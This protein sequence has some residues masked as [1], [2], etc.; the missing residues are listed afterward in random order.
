M[1]DR[2]MHISRLRLRRD[3][4]AAM[5]VLGG[6]LDAGRA[7]RLLWTLFA[8]GGDGRRDFLFRAGQGP[9]SADGDF[10]I[11]SSRPPED[12]RGLW[13]IEAKPYDPYLAAGQRLSFKLRANPTVMRDG[14]R[15]DVVTD[16][17]RRLGDTRV[18]TNAE[19]WE[20]AGRDW[21]AARA[22]RLGIAL[23][24]LRADAYRVERLARPGGARPATIASLDLS[25]A[26]IVDDPVMLRAAL[27]AG[28]GHGKA[29]GCGLL[30]V[31]PI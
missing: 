14:K 31:K 29:W 5:R 15:H 1:S 22:P 24:A 30:L 4:P 6:M 3:S 20:A 23:T 2:S 17:K 27:F 26:L 12:E 10:L 21:L 25:G 11:V 9:H 8:D 28:V 19:I 7:H 16:R 18:E 13:T